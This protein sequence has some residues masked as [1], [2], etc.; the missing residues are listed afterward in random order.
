MQEKFDILSTVLIVK[1]WVSGLSDGTGDDF[2]R[3]CDCLHNSNR[4]HQ[5]IGIHAF[6]IT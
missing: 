1:L 5:E 2:R 4:G 6:A 3:G